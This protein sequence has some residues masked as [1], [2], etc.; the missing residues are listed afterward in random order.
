MLGELKTSIQKTAL[1]LS[2]PPPSTGLITDIT[3]L[4]T[5]AIEEDL[6]TDPL[7]DP[8]PLPTQRNIKDAIENIDEAKSK[9]HGLVNDIKGELGDW[10][11]KIDDAMPEI[12][13]EKVEEVIKL[14]NT[15]QSDDAESSLAQ[16][17]AKLKLA[18]KILLDD[19][20]G[21]SLPKE[22]Y[23]PKIKTIHIDYSACSEKVEF[24]HLHP[25]P[26]TSKIQKLPNAHTVELLGYEL[27]LM[28]A[29]T[30]HDLPSREESLIVV[31]LVDAKLH[32]KVFDRTG[33]V[34]VDKTEN[35]L[36]SNQG[37]IAFK[38]KLE[39]F[40]KLTSD[41]S[42][43]PDTARQEIREKAISV[44]VQRSR[45]FLISKTK[46]LFLSA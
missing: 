5:D 37:L 11:N 24:I 16:L 9:I 28:S 18:E 34:V 4:L 45:C 27:S 26:K 44:S 10:I 8:M 29:S 3:K 21:S 19:D 2:E 31:A 15:L 12:N 36:D 13:T 33:Q 35:K 39:E 42:A 20:E 38:S 25:F 14:L 6:T 46:A 1:D 32:I 23:T 41:G 17:L 22:P 30:L 7:Q 40:I 43:L